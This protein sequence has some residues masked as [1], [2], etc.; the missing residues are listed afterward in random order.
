MKFV[1]KKPGKAAQIHGNLRSSYVGILIF[2]IE[3]RP[4]LFIVFIAKSQIAEFLET[5]M[6]IVSFGL[7]SCYQR[8]ISRM[9][10]VSV[11]YALPC[12]LYHH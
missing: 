2:L 8:L 4:W 1:G 5:S 10:S 11:I 12:Y 9:F 7:L 6:F 3:F